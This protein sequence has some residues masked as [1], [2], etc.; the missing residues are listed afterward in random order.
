MQ[1]TFP[2]GKQQFVG[3][4]T[5]DHD[6]QHHADH[7]VHRIQFTAKVQQA[8]VRF[9]LPEATAAVACAMAG[10]LGAIAPT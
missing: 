10:L 9:A 7:L 3:E 2:R 6:H 4:K 8:Q 1:E 5:D